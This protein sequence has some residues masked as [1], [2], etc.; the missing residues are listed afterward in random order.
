MFFILLGAGAL[1]L[2]FALADAFSRAKVSTVKA[3]GAWLLALGGVALMALLLLSGKGGFAF[4]VLPVLGPVTLNWLRRK[5][6]GFVAGASASARPS[7]SRMTRAEAFEV[8]GLRPNASKSDIQIAYVR[9]MR[10]A[11]PD[12][13][14]SDWLAARINQARD[15]LLG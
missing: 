12:G 14:G 6:P 13:G 2:L 4:L 15:V 5:V 7:A 11:H 1:V 10:G 8:L 9:L 3:F